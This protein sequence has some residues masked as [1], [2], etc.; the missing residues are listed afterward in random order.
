MDDLC[1]FTEFC[2]FT[3]DPVVKTH[4]HGD[5]QIGMVHSNIGVNRSMHSEHA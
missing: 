1:I 2:Q 3:G 4:T 5:N